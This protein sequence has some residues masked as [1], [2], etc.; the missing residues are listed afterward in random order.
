MK[1]LSGLLQLLAYAWASPYSLFGLGVGTLGIVTGGYGRVRGRVLEFYG[2]AASWFVRHLPDGDYVLAITLGHVI[3]GQSGASLDVA[4]EHEM[5]HVRQY[6][7]WGVLFGP[8]YLLCSLVLWLRGG[9]AYRDNPFER[10]AYEEGGG[11]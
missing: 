3:L 1:L 9:R 11:E 6:E 2:G 4:R 10:Q 7:R 8:A 5:I